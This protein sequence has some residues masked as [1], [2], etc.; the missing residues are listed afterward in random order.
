MKKLFKELVLVACIVL[1]MGCFDF[2]AD[3]LVSNDTVK[4]K[5]DL[6]C[7]FELISKTDNELSQLGL[8]DEEINEL[9]KI[10]V[11]EYFLE[12]QKLDIE[13]LQLMGYTSN[14]IGLIKSYR[15][16]PITPNSPMM[17]ASAN[18]SGYMT[19]I[20][21]PSAY[22]IRFKYR[23]V[24]NGCPISAYTN[25]MCVSW[26][27]VAPS[28][29]VIS[30][31]PSNI[32]CTTSYYSTTS[33]AFKYSSS[34][35]TVT[36]SGF[37]GKYSSF[38]LK[39]VYDD[40]SDNTTWVYSKNG[41]ITITLT[42]DGTSTLSLIKVGGAYAYKHMSC[43]ITISCDTANNSVGISFSPTTKV[44]TLELKTYNITSSGSA[45]PF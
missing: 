36:A 41:Q 40:P 3:A 37:N 25:M 38:N 33:G 43:T 17:A 45:T 24:W 39:E 16:Q 32:S 26:I 44:D 34:Q 15:G 19:Y 23:W 5:S 35:S 1:I 30:V 4:N 27:G 7:Y 22:S 8:S 14:Q 20:S 28:G 2:S 12:L 6:E 13:A 18:L 42:S 29:T 9:R 10:S 31:T 21:T 11:E